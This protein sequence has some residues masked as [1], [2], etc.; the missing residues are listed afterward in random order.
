MH[1]MTIHRT[2]DSTAPGALKSIAQYD[3]NNGKIAT[4]RF[5]RDELLKSVSKEI[6]KARAQGAHD[7]IVSRDFNQNVG[8]NDVQTFM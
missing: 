1:F 2:I 4:S 3:R 8:S 5:Y 6:T 7:V